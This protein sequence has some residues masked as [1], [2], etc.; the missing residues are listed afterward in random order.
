MK[1]IKP[2]P[3]SDGGNNGL[4]LSYIFP[5]RQDGKAARGEGVGH[6]DEM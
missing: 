4:L 6:E 1:A 5:Y 2:S 3:R